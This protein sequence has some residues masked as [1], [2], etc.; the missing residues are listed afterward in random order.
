[1]FIEEI[2][3]SA[4]IL[5]RDGSINDAD[6]SFFLFG[7]DKS[8]LQEGDAVVLT[9]TFRLSEGNQATMREIMEANLL[10][11][12]E[13]HPPL[14]SQ[15]SAGSI[16]K[17]IEGIGAGRLIDQCGLKGAR[18]GGAVVSEKHANFI[19]NQSNATARDVLQ[20]I[21]HVQDVVLRQ[22]GYTLQTE[23]NVIGDQPAS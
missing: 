13:R 6:R 7:Y 3:E 18:I 23:I 9:A 1:V 8:I 21:E 22:T 12:S 4:S 15:P 17:K 5:H 20:L 2:L 16:F 19:V 10:W 14:D 11:R